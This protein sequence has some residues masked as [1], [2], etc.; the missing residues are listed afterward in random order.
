MGKMAYS[1]TLTS[2]TKIRNA[3]TGNKKQVLEVERMATPTPQTYSDQG[4]IIGVPENIDHHPTWAKDIPSSG[5]EDDEVGNQDSMQTDITGNLAE[6]LMNKDERLANLYS[7]LAE[8]GNLVQ[9][10]ENGGELDDARENQYITGCMMGLTNTLLQQPY[11]I[12]MEQ[13]AE[14]LKTVLEINKTVTALTVKIANNGEKVELLCEEALHNTTVVAEQLKAIGLATTDTQSCIAALEGK[15]ES[16]LTRAPATQSS[17]EPVTS[18]TTGPLYKPKGKP[19][20]NLGTT[21]PSTNPLSAHHP[22]RAVI[23][24]LP[25]GIKEGKHMEPAEVVN[26]INS[27]L[28][29][30]Q[31][32]KAKHIK[33]VAATY[34]NQG[35]LIVSTRADQWAAD[36]LQFAETFLP[37]ISQGYSMSALEDK[38]WFKIQV[39]GVSTHAMANYGPRTLLMAETVHEELMAC[40][41]TYA[42]AADHIVSPPQWMCTQEEL[43]STLRSSLVFAVDDE[44]IA[45]ELLQGNS[46]AAFVR[47]CPLHAYQDRPP[48][49]QCKNCWGWDHKADSCR[50]QTR[51]CLCVGDHKEEEHNMDQECRK[52]KAL[53]ESDGMLVDKNMCTHYLHCANCSTVSYITEK[54]HTADARRC[55][56]RLEKYGTA[57]GRLSVSGS[58]GRPRAQK[59]THPPPK[60]PHQS[61]LLTKT[62]SVLSKITP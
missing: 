41:P 17:A 48:I 61:N 51:C 52:C 44:D 53:E 14:L 35:N 50:E 15:A 9:A 22:C 58:H 18:H 34:N 12:I 7:S 5:E 10:M 29:N 25:D 55:P 6:H 45:K 43:R 46:L 42:Q 1:V 56:V 26:T 27:A 33:A 40:N 37:L 59:M 54:D 47:Y 32:L 31:A 62:N 3:L 19:D 4:L 28:A 36:L 30:S 2:P 21:K 23:R 11:R 39:D 16:P 24:F 38:H 20:A 60:K 13:Q 49:K 8:A 57:R